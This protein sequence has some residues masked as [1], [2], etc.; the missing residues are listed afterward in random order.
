MSDPLNPQPDEVGG[1]APESIP[2]PDAPT[3]PTAPETPG[4]PDEPTPPGG[5]ATIAMSVAELAEALR[6]PRHRAE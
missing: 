6:G 4:V 2:A 5:H 3:T 1:G